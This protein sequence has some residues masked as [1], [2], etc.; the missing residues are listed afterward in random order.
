MVEKASFPVALVT[1]SGR[2]IGRH[3]AQRLARDGFT[4]VVNYRENSE[5]AER[6]LAGISPLR[7]RSIKLQ[8]DV[9]HPDEVAD[10][11]SGI[12]THFG[13][14]DVLVN[15]VG[16]WM[17]KPLIEMTDTEW[18]SVIDGNLSS[19]FYCTRGALRIMRSQEAGVIINLGAIHSEIFPGGSPHSPAY[20]A[21]KAASALLVRSLARSEGRFNIRV[22]AVNPG[23]I[24]TYAFA[25]APP[26]WQE[27]WANE[28]ALPRLGE[29]SDIANA[30]SF[31]V[32]DEASFITGAILHVHG[33]IW[34]E[35]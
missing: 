1:G 23:I 13:R 12:E 25:D 20:G 30:V 32:S 21:A 7:P 10:L 33:G 34:I 18:R 11:L 9:A 14:L 29:C 27:Q 8:A 6:T 15:N 5:E 4:I 3:I 24:Q 26:E 31:L 16:P 19:V 35:S 17:S 2:G 28:T 22:N